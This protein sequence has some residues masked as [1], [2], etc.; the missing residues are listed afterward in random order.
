[1]NAANTMPHPK[2]VNI[3]KSISFILCVFLFF[4]C[5]SFI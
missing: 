1:L 2:P 4:P 3:D 5:C